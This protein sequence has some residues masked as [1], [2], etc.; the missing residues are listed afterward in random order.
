MTKYK[1]YDFQSENRINPKRMRTLREKTLKP[2]E[3]WKDGVTV[4]WTE[5]A[6]AKMLAAIGKAPE[7]PQIHRDD[8][9]DTVQADGDVID[10]GASSRNS[11]PTDEN[12][13]RA[14]VYGVAKN[15]RYVYVSVDGKKVAVQADKYPSKMVGKTISLKRNGQEYERVQ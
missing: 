4:W 9:E 15:P 1:Q 7:C 5:A 2:K 3:W 14:K 10:S 12:A 11:G 6:Q 13:I 8:P